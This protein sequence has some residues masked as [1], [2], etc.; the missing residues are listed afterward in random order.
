MCEHM[1]VGGG[2]EKNLWEFV[3]SYHGS[4]RSRTLLISLST[5]CLNPL[6]HLPGQVLLFFKTLIQLIYQ[7]GQVIHLQLRA[8]TEIKQSMLLVLISTV[9]RLPSG[10]ASSKP[11]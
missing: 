5:K 10:R 3:L 11:S 9:Q 2:S 1:Y 4:I 6:S 8:R 7:V